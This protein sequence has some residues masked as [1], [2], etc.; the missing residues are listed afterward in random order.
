MPEV[1]TR[2][3]FPIVALDSALA[4]VVPAAVVVVVP[5]EPAGD[6]GSVVGEELGEDDPQA[7]VIRPTTATAARA[8]SDLVAL[9]RGAG[10]LGDCECAAVVIGV[11]YLPQGGPSAHCGFL[12]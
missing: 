11:K 5:G 8:M 4:T 10:R 6:R 3:V 2:M 9:R 7:A 1:F 12:T